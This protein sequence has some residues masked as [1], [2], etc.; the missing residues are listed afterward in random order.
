[1]CFMKQDKKDR[2]LQR[3]QDMKERVE[4]REEDMN[5]IQDMINKV[6]NAKVL[7]AIEP[8]CKKQEKQDEELKA[9]RQKVK[10]MSEE[11]LELRLKCTEKENVHETRFSD[12]QR[13]TNGEVL[14]EGVEVTGENNGIISAARR[15]V[16]LYC[17]G[18]EAVQKELQSGAGNEDAAMLIVVKD[19]LKNEM[20]VSEEAFSELKIE[21]VFA[22]AKEQWNTLYVR[23]SAESSVSKLYSFARN[24]RTNLRLVP[25]IPKQFYHRYK[26]LENQAYELRNCEDRYRTKVTMGVSDLLLYKRKPSERSWKIHTSSSSDTN[27]RSLAKQNQST[28]GLQ[29]NLKPNSGIFSA[30]QNYRNRE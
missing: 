28:N 11:I 5:L 3:E 2:V 16:G 4:Q 23:F 20:N 12:I 27:Q 24:L 17:V 9:L 21:K 18:P 14:E 6:V 19:F 29:L 1:M 25:Y 30:S 13:K 26:D 7:A 8:V 22:P 15:T 10:D